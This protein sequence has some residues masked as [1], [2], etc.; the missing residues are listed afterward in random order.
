MATL[1]VVAVIVALVGGGVVWFACAFRDAGRA[2]SEVEVL[3]HDLEV[4]QSAVVR[5]EAAYAERERIRL[6]TRDELADARR[7][8]PDA[9]RARGLLLFR[10]PG[11]RARNDGPPGAPPAA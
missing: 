5:T 7:A 3:E 1:I 4:Q 11:D 8:G 10:R 6:E 9:R 2:A